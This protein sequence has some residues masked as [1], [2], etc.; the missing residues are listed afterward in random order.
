[1]LSDRY[2]PLYVY[3]RRREKKTSVSTNSDC[4]MNGWRSI[5]GTQ[6]KETK[7]GVQ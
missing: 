7:L 6:M 2:P 5:I 1:M 3:E 4:M